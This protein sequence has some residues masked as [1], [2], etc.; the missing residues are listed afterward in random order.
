MSVIRVIQQLVC[1]PFRLTEH[2]QTS[3]FG[4][5]LLLLLWAVMNLRAERHAHTA[6]QSVK[7][8][9]VFFGRDQDVQFLSDTGHTGEWCYRLKGQP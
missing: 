4:L 7:F 9:V 8:S 3:A 1:S 5:L 2:L 6:P